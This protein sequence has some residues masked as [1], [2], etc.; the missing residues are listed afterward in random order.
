M[1]IKRPYFISHAII[2]RANAL[3]MVIRTIRYPTG[4]QVIPNNDVVDKYNEVRNTQPSILGETNTSP[5]QVH[6]GLIINDVEWV[7][8][9]R[10]EGYPVRNYIKFD[11]EPSE[12]RI[13]SK[14]N[15][16]PIKVV[17]SNNFPLHYGGSEDEISFKV[18]WYGYKEKPV[19]KKCRWVEMLTK[20]DGFRN[21]PPTVT[22]MW[23]SKSTF[24]DM[25]FI[26]T[27]ADYKISNFFMR[28]NG[29]KNYS[30]PI[31]AVQNITLKQVSETQ[32]THQDIS[33]YD[34][35]LLLNIK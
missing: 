10:E 4:G 6:I 23:G 13:G 1:A 11:F 28:R 15:F 25:D 14:S 8:R 3:S 24:L 32:T 21:P 17:G 33:Y 34:E 19:L 22:L 20:A 31:R 29:Y 16:T 7:K 12:V 27:K 18:E 5:P 9:N 35:Q 2:D 26:V 30:L